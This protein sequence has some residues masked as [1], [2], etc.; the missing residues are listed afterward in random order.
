MNF[1]ENGEKMLS[2]FNEE[3]YSDEIREIRTF[4]SLLNNHF[5][6]Q[7]S[8]DVVKPEDQPASPFKKFEIYL[9]Q[10]LEQ[11]GLDTDLDSYLAYHYTKG[12]SPQHTRI[13]AF[14]LPGDLIRIKFKQF[15]LT[16]Y[17]ELFEV[18]A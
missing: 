8:D 2:G 5:I 10:Y 18:E 6:E 13:K 17:P 4:Y 16:E 3:R 1:I 14:D 15:V 12:S 7:M 9:K 11:E